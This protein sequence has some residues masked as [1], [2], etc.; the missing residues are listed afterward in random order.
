MRFLRYLAVL[1][2]VSASFAQAPQQY[3]F[4]ATGPAKVTNVT[5]TGTGAFGTTQACYW[6]IAIYPRGNA[7]PGGPSC[8]QNIS[9]GTASITWVNMPGATGYDVLVTPTT[10]FPQG[11]TCT[12]CRLALNQSAG[13]VSD[14]GVTRVDYTM[15]T[16]PTASAYEGLNNTSY[17]AARIEL[18]GPLQLLSA[19]GIYF[20]DGSQLTTAATEG[21]VTSIATTSPITGGPITTTGTI[22]CATCGVTGNPLSQFAAT[23]SAQLA[24]VLSDETG[25]GLAVFATSPVFTT[26]NLGTPTTLV[27]SNAT[28]LPLSAEP[29]ISA[30]QVHAGAA[31]FGGAAAAPTSRA[32][33]AHDIPA[34]YSSCAVLD[35][36]ICTSAVSTGNPNFLTTAANTVLPI[37]G[38]TTPLV[39]FIGG[40]YQVLNT[41]VTLTVPS[42]ASVPQW[43]LAVQDLTNE[44]MVAGDF[45]A[46]NTAPAYQYTAPTCPSPGTALSATN[47]AFWFDLATNTAKTC[48]SNGGAYSAF[49]SIV[50]G[51][52]WVDAT[53]KVLSVALEPYRLNPYKR[54]ELFGSGADGTLTVTSGTTTIDGAK[55]YASV[56]VSAGTITHTAIGSSTLTTGVYFKSQNPVLVFGTGLIDAASKGVAGS[57][58]GTGTG[59]AGSTGGLGATGGG[60]GGSGTVSAA[61]G[62]GGGRINFLRS[63][64]SG[65]GG[66][67]GA[68]T[69]TAGGNGNTSSGMP[70]L[71]ATAFSCSGTSGGSGAGDGTNAG[72]AAGVS[73]GLIWIMAP[74]IVVDTGGTIRANGGNGGN[75]AGGNGGG[76]GGGGAGCAILNGGYVLTSSGTFTAT[77]GTHGNGSG[78]GQNGGDGATGYAQANKLW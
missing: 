9:F 67:A 57:A 55:Q 58:S 54:Y 38:G 20:S 33:V 36:A 63:S 44:N 2:A 46:M 7:A 50:I 68:I 18:S 71:T 19:S 76:G 8:L 72:G 66:A 10:F 53:P 43:I 39:M 4:F 24:G 11:A 77:G 69:P 25:T 65:N 23:S 75:S 32:L 15:A 49:P 51:V 41:N 40:V 6:I 34:G 16:A 5:A 45:L 14:T 61:G 3:D 29:N 42:T 37:N 52:V 59:P 62:A 28:G 22:A 70:Q 13:P 56:I 26:P 74:S 17:S 21:T 48:T 64:S 73:G 47:P 1:C 12:G 60:G 35:N 31:T 27:L 30:N 78:T